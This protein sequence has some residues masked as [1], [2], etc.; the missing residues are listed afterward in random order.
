MECPDRYKVA[1]TTYQFEGEAEYWWGTM[2]P[3]EGE[4]PMTWDRLVELLDNKYY[5]RD[6]RRTKE[7]EFLT[8]KQGRMSVMEYAVRFNELS[9]FA[10]HQVNTEER[11]MDHFEQG[12]RGDI[13]SIIAGQTFVN[14]QE[15]YQRAVKVARVLEEN[16][17]EAQTLNLER[18]RR[19]NFKQD[20]QSR[21]EKRNR[22]NYPP[23]K[24][25]QPMTRPPNPCRY[26]GKLHGGV[27]LFGQGRC[28]E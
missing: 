23:E 7:R 19:E 4:D 28:Y 1:L 16:E 11:K 24:G 2:K 26:C 15:M 20:P 25:K 22:P 21:I 13:K 6:I 17:K 3:R 14:F 18:K 5:P 9:R 12:L 10:M 8:L 27:C